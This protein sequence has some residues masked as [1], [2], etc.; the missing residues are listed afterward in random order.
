LRPVEAGDPARLKCGG[1]QATVSPTLALTF[2]GGT[3]SS[4]TSS[5]LPSKAVNAPRGRLS[6]DRLRP[7]E[8]P[9]CLL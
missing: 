3:N 1:R 5:A 4:P 8:R 2:P 6:W 7:I 9:A